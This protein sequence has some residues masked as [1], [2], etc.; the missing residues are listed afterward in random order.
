[1][2]RLKTFRLTYQKLVDGDYKI[3]SPVRE[4]G[5]YDN[6]VHYTLTSLPNR[7]TVDHIFFHSDGTID[8][9]DYQIKSDYSR[10]FSI[11][12]LLYYKKFL[13]RNDD[14]YKRYKDKELSNHLIRMILN[15][16]M[17]GF[18][19]KNTFKFLR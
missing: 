10:Y 9:G 17:S 15:M 14:Q 7:L 3:I 18:F 13:M 4:I 8:I 12:S 5:D 19:E 2:K 6:P 1:M 11:S 16:S